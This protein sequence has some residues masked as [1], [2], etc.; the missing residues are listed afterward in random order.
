MAYYDDDKDDYAAGGIIAVGVAL[1][2][3]AGYG[4]YSLAKAYKKVDC[5]CCKKN[6]SQQGIVRIKNMLGA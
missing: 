5:P 6:V 4:V 3:A 2:A 1:L